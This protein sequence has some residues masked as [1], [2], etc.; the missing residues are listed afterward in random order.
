MLIGDLEP[1]DLLKM[2]L[3][4]ANS[5]IVRTAPPAI[6]PVPSEAGLKNTLPAP[7]VTCDGVREL[8]Y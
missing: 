7:K 8:Y 2:L 4:P 6:T 3:I 1:N 5:Q